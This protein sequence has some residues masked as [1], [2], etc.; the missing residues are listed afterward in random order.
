MSRAATLLLLLCFVEGCSDEEQLLITP[1]P[2]AAPD[3]RLGIEVL[4]ET[5]FEPKL[6]VTDPFE[7][8]YAPENVT[9]LRGAVLG[10][11][12]A[13]TR[14]EQTFLILELGVYGE[15]VDVLLAPED[16]LEEQGLSIGITDQI[17]ATGSRAR[18][19]ARDTII[20]RSVRAG[21]R[22]VALRDEAGRALWP[23]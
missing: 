6:T 13:A 10:V 9:T 1:E 2:P 15:V 17:E 19:N 16:Y 11:R 5:D 3:A 20:A 4:D 22:T 18:W 21:R 7:S 8:L 23:P 14:E 12:R